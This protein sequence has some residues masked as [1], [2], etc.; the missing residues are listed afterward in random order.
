MTQERR[1]SQAER[2]A[3]TKAGGRMGSHGTESSPVKPE[4]GEQRSDKATEIS[5]SQTMQAFMG[6][7]GI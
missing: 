1:K 7:V 5:R 2:T 4:D 6:P 3:C